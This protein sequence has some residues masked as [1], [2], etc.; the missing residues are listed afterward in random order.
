[1]IYPPVPLFKRTTLYLTSTFVPGRC[2]R[3]GNQ[4][5]FGVGNELRSGGYDVDTLRQ[6]LKGPPRFQGNF[7]M[8]VVSG[9]PGP[10]RTLPIQVSEVSPSEA[11]CSSV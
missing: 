3:V 9:A 5:R 8:P 11:A 7:G 10:A 2:Q 1:M 6:D 4:L